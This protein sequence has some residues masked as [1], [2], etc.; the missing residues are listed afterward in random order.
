MEPWHLY[1]APLTLLLSERPKLFA[2]LAFL[3]AIGLP[4][5]SFSIKTYGICLLQGICWSVNMHRL[6][7]DFAVQ[8]YTK[9]C[10]CKSVAHQFYCWN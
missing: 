8:I 7:M 10:I 1:F 9:H 2:I 5:R 6:V 4:G 3:R